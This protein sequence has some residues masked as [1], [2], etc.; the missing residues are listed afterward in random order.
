MRAMRVVSLALVLVL[1]QTAATKEAAAPPTSGDPYPFATCPVMGKAFGDGAM[2]IAHEGREIRFCCAR[3]VGVFRADPAKYL[4]KIDAAII[5]AQKPFY[6]S[7]RCVVMTEERLDIEGL[8]PVDV[9]HANRL[10]RFCCE[11]CVG[12]FEKAPAKYL[13]MLEN[14]AI[15]RQKPTYPLAT[16]VVSGDALG[17]GAVDVVIGH[18]LFRLASKEH[19]AALRADVAGAAKKLDAA[20]AAKAKTVEEGE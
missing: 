17:D 13:K 15:R 19:V 1:A 11:D 14:V 20:A 6:P 2:T 7:D 4:A 3:C 9:V 8:D 5:E 18:R 10:V 16:C 12:E